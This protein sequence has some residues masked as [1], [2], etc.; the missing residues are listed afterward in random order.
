MAASWPAIPVI[1]VRATLYDGSY[2]EVDSSEMAF[3]IAGSMAFKAAAEKA[4]PALLEPIMRVEVTTP[5]SFMGDVIGDLNARRGRDR[6]HGASGQRDGG[7]G[8]RASGRD[9]WLR[10]ERAFDDSGTRVVQHGAVALR[11]EFRQISRKRFGKKL[12][13]SPKRQAAADKHLRRV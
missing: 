10:D 5:E 6:R 13:L 2:H 4:G 12:K 9:V 7:T 8:L 11:A 3:K 1:D